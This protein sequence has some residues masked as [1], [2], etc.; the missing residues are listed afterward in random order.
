MI[1]YS[2]TREINVLDVARCLKGPASAEK[3]EEFEEIERIISQA[4]MI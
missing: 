1:R 2:D 4:R 3:Y